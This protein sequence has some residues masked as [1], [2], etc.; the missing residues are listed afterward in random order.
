MEDKSVLVD[1]IIKQLQTVQD[2]ELLVDIVNLG[3]IYGV[4]IEQ[5]HVTVKM[6]LTVMGCPLSDELQQQIV[7]AVLAL[8][9]V[10]TCTVKLV[11]YPVWSPERMSQA[12]KQILLGEQDAQAIE[13]P[14][15]DTVTPI[16]K[17]A[18]HYPNFVQ[19]MADIGF[20]RIKIPG[21][22]NT[23]GRVMTLE[24]GAK[25]MGLDLT[26]VL[27]QLAAKGYKVKE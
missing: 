21:M 24:L 17:F 10:S 12:A 22:L 18:D 26:Q 14:V 4:E 25:A 16:K 23:V 5:D 8:P 15:I 13:A 6:T 11:W 19:D 3:L 7:Q 2:P 9:E 27:K 1:R 20:T